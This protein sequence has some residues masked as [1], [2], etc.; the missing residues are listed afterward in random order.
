MLPV[1]RHSLTPRLDIVVMKSIVKREGLVRAAE[2]ASRQL[3]S[4]AGGQQPLDEALKRKRGR[5]VGGGCSRVW[6]CDVRV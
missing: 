1:A 2:D 5:A 6:A 4:R 3:T